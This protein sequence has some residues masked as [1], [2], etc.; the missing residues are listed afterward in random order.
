MLF[1]ESAS[2]PTLQ[3][4]AEATRTPSSSA[5]TIGRKPERV[6][7]R[8]GKI[9]SQHF[10]DAGP[11]EDRLCCNSSMAAMASLDHVHPQSSGALQQLEEPHVPTSFS[12][13][14]ST[15]PS[16][17]KHITLTHLDSFKSAELY[18]RAYGFHGTATLAHR[19]HLGLSTPYELTSRSTVPQT[20]S[21][22][23]RCTCLGTPSGRPCSAP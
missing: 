11:R 6:L 9:C 16:C 2:R 15:G 1:A 5:R 18:G 4:K 14:S 19:S 20:L 10:L 8:K 12:R 3:F 13:V 22:S 23:I 17:K 21:V 7:W